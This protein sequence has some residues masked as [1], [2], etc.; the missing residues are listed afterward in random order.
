MTLASGC[1]ETGVFKAD[2]IREFSP[3]SQA[4]LRMT[5]GARRILDTTSLYSTTS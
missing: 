1:G 5:A 4:R 3:K 2:A